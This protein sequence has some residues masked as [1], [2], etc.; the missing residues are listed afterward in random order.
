MR[1]ARRA[2]HAVALARCR[3]QHARGLGAIGVRAGGC[4]SRLLLALMGAI[5]H[6]Q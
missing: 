6:V 3:W 1:D 5:E 4:S 2:Y